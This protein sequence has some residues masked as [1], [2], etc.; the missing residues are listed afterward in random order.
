MKVGNKNI[1]IESFGVLLQISAYINVHS[2]QDLVFISNGFISLSHLL[3]QNQKNKIGL[4]W[5][6]KF[7]SIPVNWKIPLPLLLLYIHGAGPKDN[8]TLKTEEEIGSICHL[9][10]KHLL[11]LSGCTLFSHSSST[12]PLI[13]FQLQNYCRTLF[14][15][16]LSL[17]SIIASVMTNLQ[18][19]MQFNNIP[20]SKMCLFF[21]SVQC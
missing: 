20:L 15:C 8:A 12:I 9:F 21:C 6:N 16:Q 1:I 17:R 3:Q 11:P 19:I 13:Y 14:L 7:P 2:I 18:N 4:N 10:G 5:F